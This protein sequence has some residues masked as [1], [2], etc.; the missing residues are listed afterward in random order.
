M[1]SPF[2]DVLV[3]L[4]SAFER[5]GVRWYLFGAQAAILHGAAR[6]TADVD[7]TAYRS[8]ARAEVLDVE[9][10]RVPVARA[11]D[12]VVMK[13]LAGRPKDVDNVVAILAAHPDD[14]DLELVRGTVRMLE[15]ALGQSD[16]SPV[17]D[18]EL[19]RRGRAASAKAKTRGERA[20]PPRLALPWLVVIS[21]GR[22]ET[23][24]QRY[25]CV[26]LRPG[27]YEA[28]AGLRM[29][30]V[31]LAE[32]PRTRDTLILRMLGA[33]RL[34]EEALA[35]LVALPVDAWE[36]SI[37]GPL[38]IHFRLASRG[39]PGMEEDDVSANVR[40]WVEN[41]KRTL[42]EEGRDE[43]RTEEAARCLLAVLR[44]RSIAVPDAA[45]ERILAERDSARLERWI[46]K[47]VVAASL[48]EVLDE[49]S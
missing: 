24:I 21:P 35:D 18:H 1:P 49:P 15:E 38:V 45:R 6:L 2:A 27:L 39:K 42:H 47:A 46:E 37:V 30:V 41:F 32:L 48:A 10:V 9:G 17:L 8:C 23:V 11:E 29:R 16:L 31:V 28:V 36:A 4:A 3:A 40:A 7:V 20:A 13:L 19:E 25:G 14:L 22:P 43:G 33:G 34:F 12:I 5:A 26:P 44:G